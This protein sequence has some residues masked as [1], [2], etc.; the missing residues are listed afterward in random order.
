VQ[1]YQVAI[2]PEDADLVA[3]GRDRMR[4]ERGDQQGQFRAEGLPPG[5]YLAVAGADFGPEDAVDPAFLEAIRRLATPFLL[6]EGETR[7][8]SLT[9]A[10][11]P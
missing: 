4:W 6:A 7:T 2:F 11:I 1:D 5:R 10:T 9:L 3:R 8:L